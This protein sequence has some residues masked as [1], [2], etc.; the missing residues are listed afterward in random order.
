MRIPGRWRQGYALDYHIVRSEFLYHDEYGHP[1]FESERSEIG[2]LLYR[3]KYR[4]DTTVVEEL[5]DSAARFV[6]SWSPEVD[7]IVPVPASRSRFMQPVL[8][9]GEAFAARLDLTFCDGCLRK[10][11]EAPELKNV[12]E[13][14]E[15]LALLEGLFEVDRGLVHGAGVLLIDDLY[16]S[17]ATLN[18]AADALLDLGAAAEIFALALTRTR[19]KN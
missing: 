9:F 8:V 12:H 1:V 2:E 6:K 7:L 18:A 11:R 13:Y 4:A 19:S 15:R 17:G 10:T 3:L 16:R 5:A 14:N